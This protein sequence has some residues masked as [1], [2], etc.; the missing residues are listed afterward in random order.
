MLKADF[1]ILAQVRHQP[2][3]V[4]A[5]D[6]ADQTPRTLAHG[7]TNK[8]TFHVYLAADGIHKVVYQNTVPAVLLS[9]KHERDGLQPSE[10]VPNGHLYPEACDFAFCTLLK[11]RGVELPFLEWN[12]RQMVRR[13]HAQ[14]LDELATGLAA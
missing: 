7:F 14:I 6:L 2:V 10:C 9:H 8:G 1:A 4:R 5:R 12:D 13:Y 3:T 11:T